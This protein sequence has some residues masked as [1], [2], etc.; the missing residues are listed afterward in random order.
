MEQRVKLESTGSSEARLKIRDLLDAVNQLVSS[1]DG[2]E[3][4]HRASWP[5]FRLTDFSWF[6][7]I[8]LNQT[9]HCPI[10]IAFP[11]EICPEVLEAYE[12]YQEQMLQHLGNEKST[13]LLLLRAYFAPEEVGPIATW[14]KRNGLERLNCWCKKPRRSQ[15]QQGKFPMCFHSILVAIHIL[16]I[17]RSPAALMVHLMFCDLKAQELR[18]STSDAIGSLIFYAGKDTFSEFMIQEKISNFQWLGVAKSVAWLFLDAS[19]KAWQRNT[20]NSNNR[21]IYVGVC[22]CIESYIT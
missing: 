7:T 11:W 8:N 20:L 17:D 18:G 5:N 19:K 13:E 1:L 12:T 21:C 10:K 3:D 15:V 2:S 9:F 22:L 16:W 6:S 14:Q 4:R